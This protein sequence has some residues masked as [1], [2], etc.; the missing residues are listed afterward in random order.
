[1]LIPFFVGIFLIAILDQAA[2][3]F[4]AG[5]LS[6]VK[7]V[8]LIEDVFHL[9]YIE[10]SGAGFG[11]FKDYTWMLTALTF[12]VVLAVVIYVVTKRPRNRVLLTALTFMM[13]GAVGNLIDRVRLGFVIDFFDFTLIDFPVFNVSDCFITVGA[14]IFAVY[15]LF[16]S[17]KKEN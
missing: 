3:F 15:V 6:G 5:L 4:A 14:I 1:M 11:I 2:K 7:T 16:L 17:D 9:T 10:N 13:G 12:V 8:P